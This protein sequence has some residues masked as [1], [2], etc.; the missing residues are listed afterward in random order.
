[1]E[2]FIIPLFN[3]ISTLL[4]IF[5]W[6]VIGSV[7]MSWLLVFGVVNTGNQLVS[8]LSDFLYRVTEPVLRPIRNILP[9]FGGLDLSPVVLLLG[10]HFVQQFLDLLFGKI[11]GAS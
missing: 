1:M 8:T 5:F 9:D 4:D 10:I 2:V 6:L 11:V 7:I 3:L